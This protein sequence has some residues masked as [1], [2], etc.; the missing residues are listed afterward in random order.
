[1]QVVWALAV[2]APGRHGPVFE[3]LALAMAGKQAL[4]DPKGQAHLVAFDVQ[5]RQPVLT[6]LAVVAQAQRE[7]RRGARPPVLGAAA[8]LAALRGGVLSLLATPTFDTAHPHPPAACCLCSPV[9]PGAGRA[10]AHGE[11]V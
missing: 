5:E 8:M 10:G 6:A 2:L 3:A 9:A 4:S 1:M 11:A 7:R